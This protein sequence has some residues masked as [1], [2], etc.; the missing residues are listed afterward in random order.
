MRDFPGQAMFLVPD[1]AVGAQGRAVD[2]GRV[3][4]LQP[5]AAAAWPDGAPD[6]R[7]ALA[8]ALAGSQSV[9]PRYAA[10]ET[11]RAPSTRDASGV[12][13]DRLVPESCVRHRRYRVAE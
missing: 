2:G 8:A 1:A 10:S 6:I 5:R 12:P 3:A 13:Q 7:S 4:L 11:V 9:V